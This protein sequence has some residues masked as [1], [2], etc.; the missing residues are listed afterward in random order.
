MEKLSRYL[1]STLLFVYSPPTKNS[2]VDSLCLYWQ[3]NVIVASAGP[4]Y[5]VSVKCLSARWF[6][7]E[8]RGAT[9]RHNDVIDIFI[10]NSFS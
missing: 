4:F 8:I 1:W 10:K 5:A 7:I 6:L 9:S 2:A 3:K